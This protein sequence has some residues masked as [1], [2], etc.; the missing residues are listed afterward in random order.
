VTERDDKEL[1]D[2]MEEMERQ[3]REVPGDDD[4]SSEDEAPDDDNQD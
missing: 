4:N 1:T 3:N 2:M